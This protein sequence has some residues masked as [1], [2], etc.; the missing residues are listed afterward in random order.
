MCYKEKESFLYSLQEDFSSKNK[1]SPHPSHLGQLFF[2]ITSM[3]SCCSFTYLS[4]MERDGETD[5]VI[6]I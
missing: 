2:L 1:A 3:T 6:R 5:L 4:A